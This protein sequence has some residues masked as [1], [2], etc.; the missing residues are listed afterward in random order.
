MSCIPLM[1]EVLPEARATLMSFNV[2]ALSLGCAFGAPL[3]PWLYGF[4]FPAVTAGAVVF[5]VLALL[6]LSKMGKK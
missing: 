5:N 4:G 6:A 1:T 2:A 3:A